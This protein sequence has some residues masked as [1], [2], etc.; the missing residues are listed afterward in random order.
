MDPKRRVAKYKE[1]QNL[2]LKLNSSLKQEKGMRL[3]MNRIEK[4]KNIH[5]LISLFSGSQAFHELYLAISPCV[6]IT[7]VKCYGFCLLG[8]HKK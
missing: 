3:I 1:F 7:E 6:G 4:L 2:K 8:I 5:S